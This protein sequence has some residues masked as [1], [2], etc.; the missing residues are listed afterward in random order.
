MDSILLFWGNIEF[1]QWCDSLLVQD[2]NED[3]RGFTFKAFDEIDF[4]RNVHRI[5]FPLFEKKKCPWSNAN[6]RQ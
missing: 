2:R 5:A 6:L 4:L 1:L 3:R